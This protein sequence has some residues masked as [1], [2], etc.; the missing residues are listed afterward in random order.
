M[1]ID[2]WAI[3][4]VSTL[5]ENNDF[6][7]AVPLDGAIQSACHLRADT[8]SE[9]WDPEPGDERFRTSR[10]RSISWVLSEADIPLSGEA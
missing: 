2:C 1:A 10:E 8:G 3:A 6:I 5:A 9:S 4:M 7:F